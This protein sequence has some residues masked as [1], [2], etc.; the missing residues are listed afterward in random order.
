MSEDFAIGPPVVNTGRRRPRE[1]PVLHFGRIMNQ[2]IHEPV[3]RV[4][5]NPLSIDERYAKSRCPLGMIR[6]FRPFLTSLYL[7]QRF[8]YRDLDLITGISEMD[9]DTSSFNHSFNTPASITIPEISEKMSESQRRANEASLVWN[10]NLQFRFQMRRLLTAWLCK[11][12]QAKIHPIPNF[13]TLEEPDE[14]ALQWIDIQSRCIYKIDGYTLVKSIEMYLLASSWGT[15]EP[16]A[17]RNPMTNNTFHLGQLISIFFKIY[18][19]CGKNKKR[20]PPM[21]TKFHEAKFSLQRFLMRNRP[22]LVMNASRELFKEMGTEDAVEQ[23]LDV[24]MEYIDGIH[25]TRAENDLL[26]WVATMKTQEEKNLLESWR[27]VLPDIIQYERFNYFIRPEWTEE[28]SITA[29]IKVLWTATEKYFPRVPIRSIPL[30]SASIQE[31]IDSRINTLADID[32]DHLYG[33]IDTLTGS[34]EYEVSSFISDSKENED[35]IPS[36]I[37]PSI[38]LP[39]IPIPSL[40]EPLPSLVNEIT[41]II[42]ERSLMSQLDIMSELALSNDE[43]AYNLSMFSL[44]SALNNN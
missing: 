38:P 16:I 3:I 30:L 4:K 20:V 9:K 42:S 43:M 28:G 26:R 11:K 40:V 10:K 25:R 7:E 12:S 21:L 27:R 24:V 29:L 13:Q 34:V 36:P 15:P 22:E 31:L 6:V 33:V 44:Y 17:P 14:T 41:S 32:V 2:K 18:E 8:G 39:P 23:W 19:W 35:S 1:Q 37:A 5:F